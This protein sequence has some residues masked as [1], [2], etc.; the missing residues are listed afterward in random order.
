MY[1]VR[2]RMMA[3]ALVESAWYGATHFLLEHLSGLQA[4]S[5]IRSQTG[6]KRELRPFRLLKAGS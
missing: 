2:E 5:T 6:G 4:I 1:T 3:V